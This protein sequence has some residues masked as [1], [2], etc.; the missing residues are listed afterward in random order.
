[1]Q[2]LILKDILSEI[3][4]RRKAIRMPRGALAR[5]SGVCLRTAERLLSGGTEG[6]RWETVAAMGQ[7]VGIDLG[8]VR[9]RSLREVVRQQAKAKAREVVAI[10]QGDAALEGQAVPEKELKQVRKAIEDSVAT[11]SSVLLWS[12]T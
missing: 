4:S 7:A 8:I 3:E 1:M 10:A 9:K 12:K 5:R 6:A 11:G 2:I